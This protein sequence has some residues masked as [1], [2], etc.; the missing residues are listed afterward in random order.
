VKR[1]RRLGQTILLHD[2]GRDREA[3]I[4]ALPALIDGLRA[5][6]DHFVSLEQMLGR[7]R[8][9]LMPPLDFTER[10]WATVDGGLLAVRAKVILAV[11]Y[12][13]LTGIILTLLRSLVYGAFS[14]VQ[15]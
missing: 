5:E 11:R 9:E 7:S 13:F 6:G 1:D 12:L 15:K 3:T 8:D 4:Q 14:I 2:R 10:I